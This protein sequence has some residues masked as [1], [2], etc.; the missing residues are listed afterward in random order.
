MKV[1]LLALREDVAILRSAVLTALDSMSA[2]PRLLGAPVAEESSSVSEPDERWMLR[3]LELAARGAGRVHPNPLV[4][5]VLVGP[6]GEV[7]GEG[8]HDTYG[9][10]HAEVHAIEEA[11]ERVE[12]PSFERST[13]YVNLEPCNHEGKTPPCAELILEKGIGRLVVG[14][15]D[16]YPEARAAGRSLEW[17]RDRGVEVRSGVLERA[18]RRLNEA[19]LHHLDTGRPLVTVKV[20]STLDGAIATD[21]G[22]ARWIS[23]EPA[24]ELVHRWR[25]NSDGVLVGRGTARSDD[26]RLTV[27]HVEGPQPARLVL[28]R[29]GALSPTL[30]L[31]SDAHVSAT[32]ALVGRGAEPRYGEKLERGGGRIVRV[33]EREGHLDL[34]A[35]LDR[36]GRSGH[37]ER[38][39]FQSLLVEAGSGLAT[40]LFARD[41]VDRFALFVAP[42]LLGGGRPV[43]RSLGI[44]AMDRALTFA[45]HRWH[46]V[47][48]DGLFVGFRRVL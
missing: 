24:R 30:N 42:K 23:G 7:L 10:P 5:A 38:P 19:Y 37:G 27:R 3:C 36:V 41:L 8:F 33:P 39:F 11:E 40:A 34:E 28:D 16:P 13:L 26:P 14:I 25:A 20:A 21:G 47:G 12:V 32:L 9:G 48:G 44:D 31:F 18:G 2:F 1:R 29:P 15:T 45:E 4:G 22:D 43:I 35:V 6:D 17:L 46:S